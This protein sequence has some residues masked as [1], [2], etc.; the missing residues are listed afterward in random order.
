MH[1]QKS[2]AG[3]R[4]AGASALAIALALSS[5][6][7]AQ[8]AAS[9][10]TAALGEVIVTGSRVARAGFLA[11]TPT[12]VV[13]GTLLT[14]ATATSIGG[15]LNN[16]PAFKSDY[17]PAASGPRSFDA[18]GAF[19]ANL[20]SLGSIRTLTLV[21]GRR[22]T[23][24]SP[25][26]QA[27]L[28]L[29]PSIL[30]N[31]VEVVTGGA[32]AAY[33]SDAVAGVV[34]IQL[35]KNLQGFSGNV[36]YG[37][38]THDD[39]RSYFAGL[40]FGT[41]F[42][43]GKGHFTVGGEYDKNKGAGE[44]YSR[45]WGRQEW[46]IM[47]NPA[48]TGPRNLLVP[49]YRPVNHTVGG[50]V[51]SGPL[52]G[53][54]FLPNGGVGAFNYGSIVGPSFQQGGDNYGFSYS[55]LLTNP[56]TRRNLLGR[57]DY[58][59][60]GAVSVYAEAAWGKSNSR[61]RG[62][63]VR[64]TA[65][66]TIQRTNPFLPA[67]VVARM[68]AANVTTLAVGRNNTDL[69]NGVNDV[70]TETQRYVVGGDA[71][72]GG[73]WTMDAFVQYGRT[74]YQGDVLNARNQANFR[75]AVDAV[76]NP[77]NGQI[78]CR[79]TLTAPTNGC[80]PAN[81]FGTGSISPQAKAYF[82]G[83]ETFDLL[84]EQTV[85]AANVR[86]SPFSTWAGEVSLA[87]G[88]EHRQEKANGVSDPI[89][90]VGGW[91]VGN[92]R[93][94]NGKIT[95]T[96]GYAEAVT[97]LLANQPFAKLLE[98]N[99]AIRLTDYSTSGRVTT[100]KVGLSYEL[101]DQIRLRA[102]KSRDIRAANISELYTQGV[103]AQQPIQHP[104]TRVTV[105]IPNITIGNPNLTPEVADT[106]TLGVVLKPSFIPGLDISVDRYDIDLKKAIATL[107]GQRIVDFCFSG[108]ASLCPFV[109]QTGN[110]INSVTLARFNIG[111]IRTTGYDFEIRYRRGL[112]GVFGAG[113]G[114]M[115]LQFL[116]TRVN[117]LVVND[118]IT[119]VDYAGDVGSSAR[120]AY[121]GPKWRWSL[122]ATYDRGPFSAT[123]AMRYVGGGNLNNTWGPNE[124]ADNSVKSVTYFDL[125]AQYD[126]LRRDNRSIQLYGNVQNLFDKDPPVVPTQVSQT[127]PVIYDVIGR[128]F[129]AGVRFSY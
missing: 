86:G 127:N 31:N 117:K 109:D 20:R 63:N 98:L 48:A 57:I 55:S 58:D 92:Q 8:T 42:A 47:P 125:S 10:E 71:E 60:D 25:N 126:L 50:I 78:V 112:D 114:N 12:T 100:W 26:G 73:G 115:T 65:P 34:N 62:N 30:I 44:A 1:N 14:T 56:L 113:A 80:V 17:S 59:F 74:D 105:S 84:Y 93:P 97:P 21:D 46:G 27:D 120:G 24:S 118:L 82:T 95:V 37:Q 104:V 61:G 33:G 90:A 43:S 68:T 75:N 122:L 52:K 106:T 66:I 38:S 9:D 83:D 11:P 39:F 107:T 88:L 91:H 67:S 96:E 49:D 111:S 28:N 7:A 41:S 4:L 23:P 81:I 87:A 76:V 129:R 102:T 94:I 29:I 108:T 45:D 70:S 5:Q 16:L 22:L 69:G 40:A 72:L 53:T 85:A 32:S 13:A 124:I 51:Q 128:Q 119:T 6:A 79:S 35:K 89:S 116:G 99:T 110:V 101:N 19:F 2:T 54:T 64:D 3:I 121:G 36:S 15:V 123:G 77:A 18:P 103:S